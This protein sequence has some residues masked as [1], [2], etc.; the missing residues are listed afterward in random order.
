LP[1]VERD[2]RAAAW[3]DVRSA[4]VVAIDPHIFTNVR[5]RRLLQIE[6]ELRL[7]IGSEAV[8]EIDCR[9]DVRDEEPN[10]KGNSRG[11]LNGAH[12]CYRRVREIQR[13]SDGDGL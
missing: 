8:S 3:V 2:G 4:R 11:E 7:T 13:L 1:I 5:I 6:T 9:R 10:G 12:V